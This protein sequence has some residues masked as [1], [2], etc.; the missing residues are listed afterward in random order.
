MLCAP[1]IANLH[2]S[3][4]SRTRWYLKR[5]TFSRS[6]QMMNPSISFAI[7]A[8]LLTCL[9]LVGAQDKCTLVCQQNA[10][11]NIGKANFTDHQTA[12]GTTLT[13]LDQGSASN[14]HCVCPQTWTGLTCNRKFES[15][16][17][18]HYCYVSF[19]KRFEYA[20]WPRLV[21]GLVLTLLLFYVVAPTNSTE[22]R[23]MYPWS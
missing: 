1:L 18:D 21:L 9:P 14:M 7:L 10:P 17:G 23:R 19:N 12:E 6:A 2:A 11:C 8:F 5:T 15:C 13:F 16:D 22:R 20:H 3:A 4:D